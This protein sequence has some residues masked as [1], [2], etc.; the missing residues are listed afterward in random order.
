MDFVGQEELPI[1]CDMGDKSY[2]LQS[3]PF[4]SQGLSAGAIFTFEKS[5]IQSHYEKKIL[6]F[7]FLS[8]VRML[9]GIPVLGN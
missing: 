6:T 1:K 7:F 5:A 9:L 3:L 8:M 2:H 4:Y